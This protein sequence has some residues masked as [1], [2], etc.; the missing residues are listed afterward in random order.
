MQRFDS[1][2]H[3]FPGKP[4]PSSLLCPELS[5]PAAWELVELPEIEDR[6]LSQ[7]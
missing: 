5:T 7:S 2:D 3:F 6:S 1:W 4:C